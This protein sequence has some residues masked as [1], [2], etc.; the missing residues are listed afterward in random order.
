MDDGSTDDTPQRLAPYMD[1]ICYVRQPNGGVAAARN[2]GIA[3]AQGDLIAFLDADDVW[4]PRKLEWQ[5]RAMAANPGIGLLGS[6]VYDWPAPAT[7][8]VQGAG[9][10]RIRRIEREALAVRNYLATSSVLARRDLVREIG[11]FDVA[12]RGPEDHDYWLRAVERSA[13]GVLELPLT[14]YRS[15]PGS[16]SKRAAS[17]EAGMLRILDSLDARGFWRGDRLLRRRA[18]GYVAYACSNLHGAAGDQALAVR[19]LLRSLVLYPLP[20]RRSEAGSP[21]VRA[22]RMAVLLLRLLGIKRP[23]TAG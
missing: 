18:Y 7:P 19:R 17:M 9:T 12:L 14:G 16:L 15:A 4:H 3:R 10:A 11:P 2:T 22:R 5:T 21:F 20:L 8:Q 6:A 13:I 1:R 23:E